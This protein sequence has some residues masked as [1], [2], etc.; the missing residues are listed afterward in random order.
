MIHQ[1]SENEGLLLSTH[2]TTFSSGKMFNYLSLHLRGWGGGERMEVEN[3][4]KNLN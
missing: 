4:K 2:M 3:E 1:Y